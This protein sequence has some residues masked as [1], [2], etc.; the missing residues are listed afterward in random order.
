[1]APTSQ[2]SVVCHVRCHIVRPFP[3]TY[4]V[5]RLRSVEVKRYTALCLDT[6]VI[7]SSCHRA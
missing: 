5:P 2:S 4:G 7:T 6:G 3:R 1:M